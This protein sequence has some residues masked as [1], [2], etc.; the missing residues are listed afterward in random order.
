MHIHALQLRGRN[1]SK[2]L[3][4]A[5]SPGAMDP[6]RNLLTGHPSPSHPSATSS[7]RSSINKSSSSV[8]F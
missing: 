3:S 6:M 7:A 8:S 4:F 1:K 2:L 5:V